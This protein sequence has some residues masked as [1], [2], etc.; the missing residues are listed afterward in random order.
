[1]KKK[2]SGG[3][4]QTNGLT[5]PGVLLTLSILSSNSVPD[6]DNG[7]TLWCAYAWP[8]SVHQTGDRAFFVNQQG[9]MLMFQNRSA[10]PYTGASKV[11]AFDEAFVTAGDMAS[12]VR[13]GI[14][15]GADATLW[16]PV[17]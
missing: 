3:G 6:P 16:V 10:T 17:Q 15:G 7:E 4:A 1:M 5:A 14:A 2:L 9:T 11:P 12:P 13:V 8:M